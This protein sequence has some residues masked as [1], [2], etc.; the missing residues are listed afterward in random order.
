MT[1]RTSK[2]LFAV[3]STYEGQ[4]KHKVKYLRFTSK[5]PRATGEQMEDG[6]KALKKHALAGLSTE[7]QIDESRS[8]P[9]LT[10]TTTTSFTLPE[11]LEL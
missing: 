10:P 4:N 7:Q 5:S 2:I 3:I 1:C 6:T 8:R 11:R 9:S